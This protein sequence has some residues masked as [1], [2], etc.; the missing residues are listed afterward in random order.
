MRRIFLVFLFLTLVTNSYAMHLLG[1]LPTSTS[2]QSPLESSTIKNSDTPNRRLHLAIREGDIEMLRQLINEKTGLDFN[3]SG[4]R[5]N[6]PIHTAVSTRGLNGV[7]ILQLLLTAPGI[8]INVY[9]VDG[10]TALHCA[11][12]YGYDF[13][14]RILLKDPLIQVNKPT[15]RGQFTPLHTAVRENFQIIVFLLLRAGAD[16]NARNH[17]GET[18]LHAAVERGCLEMVN[19]LLGVPGIEKN[20]TNAEGYSPLAVV[21]KKLEDPDIAE[22]DRER[23]RL[24][25]QALVDAG[26]EVI[27]P[28][29]SSKLSRIAS[30]RELHKSESSGNLGATLSRDDHVK[31]A[32]LF[33]NALI[34]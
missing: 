30:M 21:I 2:R 10:V 22:V 34:Q 26:A 32:K 19:S 1:H 25:R 15:E 29:A 7:A 18:P 16:V 14:V 20:C 9:D 24:V 28:A 11:V 12:L 6:R 33:E 3:D 4:G 31:V 8:D 27:K 17:K 13:Y 5:P 23:L